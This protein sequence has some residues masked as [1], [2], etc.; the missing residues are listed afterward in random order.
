MSN[1]VIWVR[2]S[3]SE[4]TT[5]DLEE[6]LKACVNMGWVRKVEKKEKPSKK[7]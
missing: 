2:P 7:V 6:T 4:I 3:K 1:T 5:N